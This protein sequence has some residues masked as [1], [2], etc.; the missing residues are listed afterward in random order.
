MITFSQAIAQVGNSQ[1][2]LLMGNGFSIGYFNYANLLDQSGLEPDEPLRILFNQLNTVD[3]ERVMRSVE[4]AAVVIRAY[5]GADQALTL[6]R[7]ADLLRE[8]LIHAI[9]Q[10]H[11]GNR[12]DLGAGL[13]SALLFLS[14]FNNLF[15]LNYDLLLYWVRLGAQQFRDGFGL[16]QEIQG[17]R[18]FN[19]G[20]FCEVYNLHGGLHLFADHDFEVYKQIANE[21]L[22]VDAIEATIR[23]TRRLPLYVAEGT[24]DQKLGKISR[25]PYLRYCLDALRQVS[26]VM[27]IYGHSAARNDAHIYEAIFRNRSLT[28]LYVC[29]YAPAANQADIEAEL[30]WYKAREQSPLDWT[31]VDAQSAQVW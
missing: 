27:F 10:V 8:A 17:L 7:E 22:I 26:G 9:R 11:P 29:V 6:E 5:G 28:H 16:G 20:A 1:K 30:A 24:S 19:E 23:R 3:F 4:D 31:I 15:T 25:V 21:N 13:A 18:Q 12:N 2:S 14:H